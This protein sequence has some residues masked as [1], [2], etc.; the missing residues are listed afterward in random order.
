MVKGSIV[1]DFLFLV[2]IGALHES[3]I[4]A[5]MFQSHLFTISFQR[6]YAACGFFFFKGQTG[7]GVGKDNCRRNSVFF[8]FFF[9][10]QSCRRV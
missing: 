1:R 4:M 8:F 10:T 7:H 5:V 3:Q 9:F 2:G 6:E